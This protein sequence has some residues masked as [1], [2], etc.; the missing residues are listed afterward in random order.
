MKMKTISF[1]ALLGI[2]ILVL[3]LSIS[4]LWAQM[5]G[6]GALT[7]VV[8]D[9]SG[10]MIS[11]AAVTVSNAAG[12][13]RTQ[14]TEA[15]GR[16]TFTLLPPGEYKVSISVQGFKTAEVSSVTVN[17]TETHVLNQP[18]EIGAQ[19]QEVTV[20]TTVEALETESSALGDV[21]G[22]RTIMTLPLV[23]RNYTQIMSLSPG[24]AQDVFNA[25]TL[26][27]GSLDFAVNGSNQTSNDIQLEGVNVSSV[28]TG[29]TS[30]PEGF[31][32]D[33][34]IPNPDAI[35]E[36]KVQTSMFDAGYGR[37][38]GGSVNI[39]M[40]SGTN[41]FHGSIFE[42]FRN[43]DLNANGF[44][45]NRAGLPRGKLEQNQ[46]GGTV[47]GPI[48]KNKLF[49]FFSYQGTRQIDGVDIAGFGTAS[50]PEQLTNDR[51]AAT[52]GAEFCPAN[53]PPGSPGAAYANTFVAAPPT[54]NP[55]TDQVACNGSNINPVALNLLN[56]KLPNGSYLIPTPQT[57][58]NAGQ[59]NASGFAA[60][61]KPATFADDE[62][63]Y[64]LDYAI[65]PKETLTGRYYY[66]Y[67]K[68]LIN[69]NCIAPGASNVSTSNCLQD[70]SAKLLSGNQLVSLKLTSVLGS[71]MVNELHG[72]FFYIRAEDFSTDPL[73]NAQLGIAGITLNNSSGSPWINVPPVFTIN[74]LWSQGGAST[75][76]AKAPQ[77][78]YEYSD[79][80]SLTHGTHT[81]RLGFDG[82]YI[83][84][85]NNIFYQNRGSLTF[86]TWADFMLGESGA[87]NGTVLS[88]LYSVAGS[89]TIVGGTLSPFAIFNDS[90]FA[91][92]DW[93]VNSRL[94]LN[95]GIRWEYDGYPYSRAGDNFDNWLSLAEMVPVPPTTGTFAGYNMPNNYPG[96]LP[97]GIYRRS[98]GNQMGST[99]L[100][101][102]AP[103]FGFA[104]QPFG[105]TGKFVVRGGYGIF[106]DQ[107]VMSGLASTNSNNPPQ[108]APRAASST[109]N[110]PATFQ[111]PWNATASR[112]LGF[113]TSFL[114]TPTSIL[115]SATIAQG[116]QTPTTLS[117]NLNIQYEFSPSW[118]LEL[119]WVNA[120]GERLLA[121]REFNI[122]VLAGPGVNGINESA[123]PA[124]GVNCAN[125]VTGCVTINTST[126]FNQ[127]VPI[128]GYTAGGF[129][130]AGNYGDSK[131]NSGQA[132][133]RKR[134]SHGL[135]LQA[136]Y[137]YSKT[138]TDIA[139]LGRG[140]VT[141]N[142]NDP[143]DL[144]QQ[145]GP[146]D[147]SR[148]QRLSFN[149]SYDA[150]N[151][152]NAIGFA[153][154]ALS[155][156][157]V[158]G[159]TTIQSGQPMTL[160]DPLAGAAY[161]LGTSRAQLCPGMTYANI[162][163]AGSVK[164]RVNNFFNL[165]AVADTSR[166]K[167]L[168]ACPLPI[169]GAFAG[170]P[171]A[172]GYGNTG[173]AIL[174]GPGEYNWDFS[175]TK[176]TRVG[177][178]RE[179]AVLEF[180]GEFFNVFNIAQF[181]QPSQAVNGASYGVIGSTAVASRIVQLALRYA[182]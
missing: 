147:Y 111:S 90:L 17:V 38:S 150:P 117:G 145:W 6:T 1:A 66:D 102:F 41:D 123:T 29:Q 60:F 153:G 2:C 21:V 65:S 143:S 9:P 177:G 53:N 24:V 64:N 112:I 80:L 127:R 97:A 116:M 26:G 157:G 167:G 168:A 73:Q 50:L 58:L 30:N 82:A 4:P 52:L 12:L 83:L 69:F 37:K 161:G 85:T 124:P 130:V 67:G 63:I 108:A 8:T 156:W 135:Q 169:V 105:T 134:F 113:S 154:N 68:R 55:A 175:I 162:E 54:P 107:I 132:T 16:Y 159:V 152:H 94:T 139:G 95:L 70:S 32:G 136:S 93:K 137:T 100:H 121:S 47:G 125:P 114:R 182:F 56:T 5:G 89:Q 180:R 57:I 103:R 35:R 122:P 96:V 36:F 72:S 42:F 171:G 106:F 174:L 3:G 13:T 22:N 28:A 87:Q 181:N 142:S 119:G 118:V 75:D 45:F 74:G 164:S 14:Q 62:V 91:Q 7:V 59:A 39:V 25:A 141:V 133:L 151:Y 11:G 158:S 129:S 18:L 109:A 27:R 170:S 81:I 131:Y 144:A 115:T 92:D 76:G 128:N 178:L 86:Q 23:T 138:L 51:S 163:T 101:D 99:P 61:S 44:F 146:A 49:F 120:R 104:W 77:E 176:K 78:S 165:S 34:P 31:Y 79:S 33:V 43:T 173:R 172:S 48:K 160:T 88:N 46:F 98:T 20:S 155:G 126:N 110:A 140:R 84:M 149:Y 19:Q 15:N 148:P 166:T 179:D 71:N 10:A 40:K